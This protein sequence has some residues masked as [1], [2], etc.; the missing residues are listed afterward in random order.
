MNGVGAGNCQK[1]ARHPPI[2]QLRLAQRPLCLCREGV[3]EVGREVPVISRPDW[4]P[5]GFAGAHFPPVIDSPVRAI[6]PSAR[7]APLTSLP[8]LGARGGTGLQE[9][10][11]LDCWTW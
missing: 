5:T 3:E 1:I 11:L 7:P 8:S 9:A 4:P 6:R 10:G 2:G